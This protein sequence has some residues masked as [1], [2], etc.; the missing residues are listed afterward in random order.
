MFGSKQ[1]ISANDKPEQRPEPR[2]RIYAPQQEFASAQEFAEW[3]RDTEIANIY[4]AG[5]AF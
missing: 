2:P 5:V 3:L 4:Q 1:Q